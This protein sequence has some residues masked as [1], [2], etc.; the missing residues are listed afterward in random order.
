MFV[1]SRGVWFGFAVKMFMFWAAKSRKIVFL[2]TVILRYIHF[3]TMTAVVFVS[4]KFMSCVIC[5]IAK[6]IFLLVIVRREQKCIIFRY[7]ANFIIVLQ[8]INKRQKLRT[9]NTYW[10]FL[11]TDQFVVLFQLN[12]SLYGRLFNDSGS[13]YL[14]NNFAAFD[15]GLSGLK[16]NSKNARKFFHC[17]D[18]RVPST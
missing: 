18:F 8:R 4:N 17:V 10:I 6:V 7:W 1:R 12:V 11:D 15:V 2:A 3:R 16:L 14:R 5:L 9:L 13:N